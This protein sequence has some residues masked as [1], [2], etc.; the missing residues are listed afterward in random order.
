[1]C[2]LLRQHTANP[3]LQEP[4]EVVRIVRGTFAYA[5]GASGTVSVPGTVHSWAARTPSDVAGFVTIDGGTSIPIPAGG[6]V[7][8]DPQG[9]LQSAVFV[10]SGTDAYL[11]E[12]HT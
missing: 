12:Y 9:T 11:V 6:S 8:G 5:A 1:M 4:A 10:F 2:S 3:S 7:G